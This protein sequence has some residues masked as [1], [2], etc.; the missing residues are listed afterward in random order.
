MKTS[1]TKPLTVDDYLSTLPEN[2]KAILE[3]LRKTIKAAAPEAVELISYSMPAIKLNGVLVYYAACKNH[4][5]FY[6]ASSGIHSFKEELSAYKG[7]KGAVRFP[8][9]EPLPVA[10]ITKIVKFR[11]QEDLKK[12]EE[13]QKK[14]AIS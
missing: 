2:I 4:I 13:K 1:Q 8:L 10:L 9:D 11:V 6:P 12:A 3:E 14:R 7:S 5:G